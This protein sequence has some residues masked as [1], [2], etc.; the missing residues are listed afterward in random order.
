ML[1][2]YYEEFQVPRRLLGE[3]RPDFSLQEI[4]QA[5]NSNFQNQMSQGCASPTKHGLSVQEQ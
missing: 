5:C 3:D 4:I 2:R 1:E